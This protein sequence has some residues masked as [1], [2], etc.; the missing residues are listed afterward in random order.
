[1]HTSTR[2]LVLS[3]ARAVLQFKMHACV[4]SSVANFKIGASASPSVPCALVHMSSD[5]MQFL[6]DKQKAA[7]DRKA[8][9]NAPSEAGSELEAAAKS[10]AAA[11]ASA[12]STRASTPGPP[13]TKK[14]K[15]PAKPSAKKQKPHEF[16]TLGPPHAKPPAK[17]P[18]KPAESDA[19]S[20]SEVAPAR[21]ESLQPLEAGHVQAAEGSCSAHVAN[22]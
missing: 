21:A 20:Q 7:A 22:G 3:H 14:Q 5:L 6:K 15:V 13:P 19:G 2:E 11:S 10:E 18:A 12:P 8:P 16:S 1:M 17:P 4:C 9:S